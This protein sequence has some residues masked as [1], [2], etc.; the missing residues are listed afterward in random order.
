MRL[1]L[2][3]LIAGLSLALAQPAFAEATDLTQLTE[4]ERTALRVEFRA[5][6]LDNPEVLQEVIA[7]LEERQAAAQSEGDV[8]LVEA[9]SE[10]LF[11]DANSWVGGNPDGSLT[12]VEFVDY[13]CGYCRKAAPEVK[14]LLAADPDIRLIIKEFPILGEQSALASRFAIAV[15]RSAGPEAYARV[16][17]GFFDGFRGDITEATLAAFAA[18]LG[19][20]MA[21]ILTEMAAPEVEQIIAANLDLAQKMRINGT[22]TFVVGSQMIRGFVPLEAMKQIVADERG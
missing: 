15:L 14:A 17:D 16:H 6:L 18:D 4:A 13:R 5:Y 7:V 9:N 21:A 11:A 22:P 12:V 10:A 19:L 8:A 1:T 3:S 2:P 20:D